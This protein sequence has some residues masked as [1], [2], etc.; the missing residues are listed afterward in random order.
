MLFVDLSQQILIL[1]VSRYAELFALL[2]QGF[3]GATVSS[4]ASTGEKV[5]MA[6]LLRCSLRRAR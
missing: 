6:E 5:T 2:G 4:M 3:S 1:L